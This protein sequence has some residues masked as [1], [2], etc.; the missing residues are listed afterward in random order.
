LQHLAQAYLDGGDRVAAEEC[1]RQI[2]EMDPGNEAALN[3]LAT[4][5]A[6]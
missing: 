2:L 1:C 4:M 3:M 5:G 6:S